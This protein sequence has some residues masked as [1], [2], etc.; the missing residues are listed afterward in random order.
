MR[1]AVFSPDGLQ[2]LTAGRDGT[3]RL[4]NTKDGQEVRCYR[5]G[6]KEVIQA[7]FSPDGRRVFASCVDKTVRIWDVDGEPERGRLEKATGSL[8]F[9]PNGQRLL[10]RAEDAGTLLLWDVTSR[11]QL[12]SVD[13]DLMRVVTAVLL[14]DG[15]HAFCGGWRSQWYSFWTW[16]KARRF[17]AWKDMKRG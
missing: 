14:P 11:K 15:A 8:S 13:V 4:W 10:T 17:V 3:V 6:G 12:Q 16:R 9:T 7:A 1:S 2:V 5:T